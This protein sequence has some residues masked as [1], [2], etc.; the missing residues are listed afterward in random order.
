MRIEGALWWGEDGTGLKLTLSVD[1]IYFFCQV[2]TEC[3]AYARTSAGNWSCQRPSQGDAL[4]HSGAGDN[5][6]PAFPCVAG[7]AETDRI[8]REHVR[9]GRS[10]SASQ[11]RSPGGSYLD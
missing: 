10:W 7:V 5:L 2:F 9:G 3:A 1:C 11:E 4:C 6:E 8:P